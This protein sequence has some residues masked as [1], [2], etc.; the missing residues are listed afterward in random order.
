MLNVNQKKQ[1]G[2]FI[3]EL[4]YNESKQKAKEIYSKISVLECSALDSSK[5]F[6][7]RIGFNHIIRKG[8]TVRPKTEQMRRFVLFQYIEQILSDPKSVILFRESNVRE[9]ANKYGKKVIVKSRAKFWTFVSSI[10]GCKIKVVI[11]QLDEG[12][13]QFLSIFGDKVIIKKSLKI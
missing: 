12:R 3:W 8:H 10:N 1:K 5:I 13:K 4:D 2:I 7:S 9:S 11:R 6:F